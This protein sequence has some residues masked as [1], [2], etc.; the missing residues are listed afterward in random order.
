MVNQEH[1]M[2]ALDAGIVA[3]AGLDVNEH[4]PLTDLE[5]R[6]F[7]Y[8][9]V[10]ITPH[11]AT[12]SVEYF[13]TVQERAARTAVAVLNGDLPNTTINREAIRKHRRR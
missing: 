9:T 4:E 10:I 1:L 6:L 5:D 3:A 7:S 12:E 2:D 11:S 13:E 8:D